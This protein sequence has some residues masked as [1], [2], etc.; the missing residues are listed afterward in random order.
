MQEKPR[1]KKGVSLWVVV[2]CFPLPLNSF[3]QPHLNCPLFKE[4]GFNFFSFY[5]FCSLFYNGG[6]G[7]T[8]AVLTGGSRKTL[9]LR[10]VRF[11]VILGSLQLHFQALHANLE[12]VHGLDGCLCRHG[13]VIADEACKDRTEFDSWKKSLSHPT[14]FFL[15]FLIRGTFHWRN[16][17]GLNGCPWGIDSF[18]NTSVQKYSV[19]WVC[20]RSQS[21]LDE[22]GGLCSQKAGVSWWGNSLGK[23]WLVGWPCGR[24]LKDE[25]SKGE[26]ILNMYT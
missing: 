4:A 18:L 17:A 24:K 8:L 5:Q 15:T 7:L 13:I 14:Y 9:V 11:A 21:H 25:N 3:F 22:K 26:I 19:F 10:S 23:L 6:G 16:K 1:K 2:A 20:L 12:A